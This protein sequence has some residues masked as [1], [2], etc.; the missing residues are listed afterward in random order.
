[1]AVIE[2][3]LLSGLA[4][5]VARFFGLAEKKGFSFSDPSSL[6]VK[7]VVILV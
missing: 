2:A 3:Q 6:A 4:L 7:A 1:M 5:E